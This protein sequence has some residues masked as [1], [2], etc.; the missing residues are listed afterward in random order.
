M[1]GKR[2]RKRPIVPDSI[3]NST[4]VTRFINYVM[5]GGKKSLARKLV[6][7][8]L[9]DASARL[10]KKPMEVLDKVLEN[11]KPSIEVRS[12]R[13]GG[14]NYQIPIPVNDERQETLALRWI[15][16]ASRGKS[17]K[18]F[19]EVLADELVSAFKGEGEAVKTRSDVERMAEANKVFA[20]FRW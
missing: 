3:Y 10:K 20:H 14:A 17:G 5:L 18:D 4:V 11:V 1:R 15:I 13:V 9:D 2:A 19:H 16:K 12:R 6:Y 7:G 8:A